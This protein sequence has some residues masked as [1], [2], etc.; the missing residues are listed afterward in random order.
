M[1]FFSI[2]CL[3][4]KLIA[5]GHISGLFRILLRPHARVI[6]LSSKGELVSGFSI[7]SRRL[8]PIDMYPHQLWRGAGHH[9]YIGEGWGVALQWRVMLILYPSHPLANANI[10]TLSTIFLS[11]RI[12]TPFRWLNMRYNT[13]VRIIQLGWFILRKF[14]FLNFYMVSSCSILFTD[15]WRV[16]V[17]FLSRL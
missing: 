15:F 13:T 4:I 14:V 5:L 8:S 12:C 9:E 11:F 17:D 10:V 2:A 7:G 16:F 6:R 1:W 3:S